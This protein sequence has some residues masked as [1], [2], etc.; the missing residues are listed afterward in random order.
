M[1][2]S[3]LAVR[4][5]AISYQPSAVRKEDLISSEPLADSRLLIADS[6]LADG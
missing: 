1:V 3:I 6:H 5:L 2:I 4:G